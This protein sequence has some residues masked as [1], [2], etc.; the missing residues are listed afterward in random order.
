MRKIKYKCVNELFWLNMLFKT[1]KIK[2][3]LNEPFLKVLNL[4]IYT[5]NF[6]ELD[7]AIYILTE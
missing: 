7:Y 5:V 4:E 6:N 1:C 2:L 3:P